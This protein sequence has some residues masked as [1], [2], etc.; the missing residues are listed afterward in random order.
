MTNT[1]EF[2]AMLVRSGYTADQLAKE[3]GM[4]RQSLSYKTNNK[5]EFT[6]SEINSIAKVLGLT[7]EEKEVI[8]FGG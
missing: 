5:R 4:S 8:F 2:K 3:I 1:L 6:A 7:L